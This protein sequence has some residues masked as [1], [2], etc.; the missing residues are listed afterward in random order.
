M[1]FTQIVASDPQL[2]SDEMSE[3]KFHLYCTEGGK[4]ILK[5][6]GED[7]VREFDGL[8]GAITFAHDLRPR[9]ALTVYNALGK[10]VL[11]AVV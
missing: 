9:T 4:F 8:M 2:P 6:Q 5:L 11:T 10:I 3:D 7:F 1:K